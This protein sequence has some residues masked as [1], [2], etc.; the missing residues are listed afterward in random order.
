M[1]SIFF[2]VI[3]PV[4]NVEKY[5]HQC[6]KSVL[7]QTYTN[8]EIIL[9]NDGST[10]GSGKICDEYGSE[11]EKIKVIHKKNGGLS[12]ARNSA[13]K[14]ASGDY[15]LFVDSDDYI[16]RNSLEKFQDIIKEKKPEVIA[17]YSNKFTEDGNVTQGMP[18]RKNMD[19]ILN[20]KEY[21]HRAL[22]QQRLMVGAP[23]YI[24]KRSII[25]EN[26]LAFTE[27]LLH[28]DELWTPIL[29]LHTKKIVDM[30]FRFYYYRH[31][32]MNSITRNPEYRKRRALCRVKISNLLS[33]AVKEYEGKDVD[34]FHD[35][36]SAQYMYAVYYGSL[37]ED[38][39]IDRLFP[40]KHARAF[41]YR[42]KALL[43][44]ISPKFACKMRTFK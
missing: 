39:A 27:G 35:N 5:M 16:A 2:S 26:G 23:Y 29:L 7:E 20:G 15:V 30:K 14:V 10:D 38:I 32:N 25:C 37:F 3:I 9:V 24:T 13:L 4:Y 41:K 36:I 17:A 12:S 21:Y 18:Y 44:L 19:E 1:D 31:D 40:I 28:E 34:S 43:F 22:Y 42:I 6:V 11:N 8:F 33:K